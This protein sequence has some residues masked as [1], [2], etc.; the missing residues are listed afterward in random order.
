LPLPDSAFAERAVEAV[1]DPFGACGF[2]RDDPG[3][4]EAKA[5]FAV[6]YADAIQKGDRPAG[7]SERPPAVGAVHRQQPPAAVLSVEKR[8]D[9]QAL[10]EDRAVIELQG[11][12]FAARIEREEPRIRV[13]QRDLLLRH[14]AVEPGRAI[15]PG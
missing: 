7:I 1:G 13:A 8:E 15:R 4:L 3:R 14:P 11:R 6:P 2:D 9:P 10:I 5:Q 12:H